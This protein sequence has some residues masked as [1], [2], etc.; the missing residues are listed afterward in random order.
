MNGEYIS[1]AAALRN[2]L[3]SVL[4]NNVR[5]LL[6]S[7]GFAKSG[8]TFRRSRG[9]L[10]DMINFQGS[11]WNGVAPHY[12]FFVNVGVGSSEM[13]AVYCSRPDAGEPMREYVLDR[14]WETLVPDVPSEVAFDET[15]DM[16]MFADT[17]CTNLTRVL[18]TI[19]AIDTTAVLTQWAID[20][21][22]LHRMEKTCAYLA[23]TDDSDRLVAYVSKIRNRF[24]DS[25]RWPKLNR[26]LLDVTG[27]L[28]PSLQQLRVLD[29]ADASHSAGT[30]RT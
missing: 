8:R 7:H 25:A 21:S 9:P 5:P 14:R 27:P 23:A 29:P 17:L 11:K 10:Y 2:A 19:D 13:D 22:W 30:D 6:K 4:S 3:E 28:A 18:T 16:D 12:G 20:N 26:T 15:T 24:G 1:R